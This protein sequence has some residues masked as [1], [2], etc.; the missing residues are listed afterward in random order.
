MLHWLTPVVRELLLQHT[1]SGAEDALHHVLL[2]L[3][4]S[5]GLPLMPKR[6]LRNGPAM[7]LTRRATTRTTTNS[8]VVDW[9]WNYQLWWLQLASLLVERM[10]CLALKWTMI[11]ANPSLPDARTCHANFNMCCNTPAEHIWAATSTG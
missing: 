8:T 5:R 6:C 1:F 2:V 7:T 11:Q 4:A 3:L 9:F 10:E